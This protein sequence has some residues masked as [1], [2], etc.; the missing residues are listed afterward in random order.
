[1]P[2]LRR[3]HR[4]RLCH[5]GPKH[6]TCPWDLSLVC[7][8]PTLIGVS[9]GP[10]AGT[11][12]GAHR[13]PSAPSRASSSLGG[14]KVPRRGRG[15]GESQLLA[16]THS[17]CL[18]PRATPAPG[19]SVPG[20]PW[21]GGAELSPPCRGRGSAPC[22]TTRRCTLSQLEPPPGTQ[23]R[24]WRA[25]PWRSR[26]G[27]RPSRQSGR[28]LAGPPV[29][30]SSSRHRERLGTCAADVGP[31]T[32]VLARG[33]PLAQHC[34]CSRQREG[35][36]HGE[37]HETRPS[38]QP[39]RAHVLTLAGLWEPG[40]GRV[41]AGCKGN[42]QRGVRRAAGTWAVPAGQPCCGAGSGCT[43]S[44][45]RLP[46]LLGVRGP[47]GSSGGAEALL[48][49]PKRAPGCAGATRRRVQ[50]GCSSQGPQAVPSPPRGVLLCPA[51]RGLCSA[52][53]LGTTE[54]PRG[55]DACPARRCWAQRPAGESSGQI[56][57]LEVGC[58]GPPSTTGQ[59][60]S[61]SAQPG[62][63]PGLT[64]LPALLHAGSRDAAARGGGDPPQGEPPRAPHKPAPPLSARPCKR[65][66]APP[67]GSA[68]SLHCW[69]GGTGSGTA[70][71][72]CRDPQGS[73]CAPKSQAGKGG[74]GM[75]P[76]SKGGWQKEP[77]AAPP[78]PDAAAPRC[79]QPAR[80]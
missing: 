60:P 45:G 28:F 31:L 19:R 69:A 44:C 35:R 52:P 32:P 54:Q 64:P 6:Q 74:A 68:P 76:Q 13:A 48:Q 40:R 70:P 66:A 46:G 59:P 17:P 57:R 23:L 20:R 22:Q 8:S 36:G 79:L 77:G 21:L 7:A 78:P 10:G 47:R 56:L 33:G 26:R 41:Y 55:C 39:L 63:H 16:G 24:S 14:H 71:G 72:R 30:T 38:G 50:G 3:W 34:T 73:A 42:V 43:A 9:V 25:G 51:G 49:S 75:Q 11:S 37:P 18:W 61:L 5:A 15:T 29:G 1:M 2:R 4:S 80:S 27:G 67:W 12:T 62:P 65:G 58:A 53:S